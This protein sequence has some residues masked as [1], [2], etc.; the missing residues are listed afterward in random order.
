MQWAKDDSRST[1]RWLAWMLC[2]GIGWRVL[3]WSLGM[4][5]WGD[6]VML[7][8]NFLD[9][10]WEGWLQPLDMGQVAPPLFMLLHGILM[11]IAG[12]SEWILRL[13]AL[14]FGIGALLLFA[15][16]VYDVV[17]QRSALCAVAVLAVAYYSVR[18]GSEFKPYALDLLL[19]VGLLFA[20][21]RFWCNPF[22]RW[23]ISGLVLVIVLAPLCSFPSVFVT[24]G[25][26]TGLLANALVRRERHRLYL[27]FG[28]TVLA[29]IMAVT[30]YT[31]IIAPQA[32][33]NELL[34]TLWQ[35]GFPPGG[36]FG[37]L[38][39]FLAQSAGRLM[40]YPLGG[41]H[42]GSVLTLL[43]VCVGAVS[44][45]RKRQ[46]F[47]LWIVLMPFVGNV[48]AAAL[49]WY[50]Y[51]Q[52][53]RIAQHLAPSICLLAGLGIVTVLSARPLKWDHRRLVWVLCGLSIIGFGG[54][55][56]VMARPYK[57]RGDLS[58][59]EL[60]QQT[61]PALDCR[62]LHV[63]N[64]VG[65]VPV[66]FRWYLAID[67]ATRFGV[68]PF[69]ALEHKDEPLCLLLFDAKRDPDTAD[70]LDHAL[71]KISASQQLIRDEVEIAYIYGGKKH[72]HQVRSIVVS[73]G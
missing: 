16:F 5:M 1:Y 17:E 66:N 6:E 44:L 10:S 22:G 63:V 8:L 15:R 20:G 40:A 54:M 61:L 14:V 59:R 55:A 58:V 69:E 46:W 65:T 53:A 71:K 56:E 36:G 19:A 37:F 34:K 67:S 13:P 48:A 11:Q 52:S 60:I 73:G 70:R 23:Q 72:P 12:Y 41:R 21:Y 49:Q 32:Q 57:S 2:L 50:P 43:L 3:R 24:A 45:Y 39:W 29:I 62:T 27:T 30:Q 9:R 7:A 28:M 64:T 38:G 42:F 25:V 18:H 26:I 4:P 51:G 68:D 35:G 33:A 47:L 31:A